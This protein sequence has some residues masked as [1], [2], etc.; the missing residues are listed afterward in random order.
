[1]K[2]KI[3]V[4]A[5]NP[6]DTAPLR[7]DEEIREIRAS[8]RQANLRDEFE[9]DTQP[10]ARVEDLRRALLN[11]NPQIVHFCGHGDEEGIMLEGDNGT[12]TLVSPE[13]LTNLFE[14]FAGKIECV[15]FN[16][17]YSEKQTKA[18][19]AHIQ[20]VI[21]MKK[22]IDDK[23]A[24]AFTGGFYDA[25]GGGRNIEEAFK[26]GKSAIE[27]KYPKADSSVV[28]LSVRKSIEKK[29]IFISYKSD[30]LPD[31]AV[32]TRVADELKT[33][34]HYV[35]IAK[36]LVVGTDWV[37]QI[38]EEL[39]Q[40]D[41][42]I[43]FLSEY[44]ITSEMVRGEIEY[45][46]QLALEQNGKPKTLPV[47]LA[48][49]A[50]FKQPL[51]NFLNTIHWAV[52]D[53]NDDTEKLIT[54]LENAI[55]GKELPIGESD[56]INFEKKG[57]HS[58]EF[59]PP[60]P[61]TPTDELESPDDPMAPESRFYIERPSDKRAFETISRRGQTIT[62][63]GPQQMGKT[64]LLV[65]IIREAQN[66]GKQTVNMDFQLFDKSSLQDSETFYKQFCLWLTDELDL[67]AN[68]NDYWKSELP[69]NKNCTRFIQ[70]ILLKQIKTPLLLAMDEVE[71]IFKADFRSDFFSMLRTWHNKRATNIDFRRLDLALVT[72][73]EE[74][75]LIKN[76]HV[77][78]FNVGETID[79]ENFSFE[80]LILLNHRHGSPLSEQQVFELM[81]L[82]LG[83]PY[84]S[85][86]ALYQIATKRYTFEDLMAESTDDRGPFGDHLR[87]H[88]FCLY[89][90]EDLVKGLKEVLNENKCTD[91]L[92]FFR[93]RGAGLIRTE[94]RHIVPRCKLYANYFNE[95][96]DG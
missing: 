74:Y 43:T 24:I 84:L 87:H 17:C 26:F 62:I 86:K 32:A 36:D 2:R 4:L 70:N 68:L 8:L 76:L 42:F 59:P 20:Y 40:S 10:A 63:K 54:D 66:L 73:T 34:G 82:L 61:K 50:P 14:L 31:D 83:H 9:V 52:W 19:N 55:G 95:H 65:R 21:G 25:L 96:I 41:F 22:E 5:A 18:I 67:N 16:A 13:A 80:N 89:G 88:K 49:R 79:L 47:R 11:Y 35:F 39:K 91:S 48:Y 57:D 85:R 23:E 69:N 27:I 90:E 37:R 81:D 53:K 38:K 7:L 1:M 77:S 78:P 94:G 33:K 71:R 46:Y 93:L 72:S 44:S 75:R 58:E 28:V 56:H 60:N 15:I 92:V 51:S 12:A 6:I 29:R 45:A 30:V 3:L 64:A